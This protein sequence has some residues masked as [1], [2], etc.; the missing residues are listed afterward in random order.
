M[1]F[2]KTIVSATI[3]TVAA[4]AAT[5]YFF[6]QT[7]PNPLEGVEITRTEQLVPTGLFMN[8]GVATQP[9]LDAKKVDEFYDRFSRY[10]SDY[11][12]ATVVTYDLRNT[13]SHEIE[14]FSVTFG[15]LLSARLADDGGSTSASDDTKTLPIR[16]LPSGKAKLSVLYSGPRTTD[17]RFLIDGQNVPI[18][19]NRVSEYRDPT[20]VWIDEHPGYSFLSVS[21]GTV[22]SVIFVIYVVG[23]AYMRNRPDL[24][25]QGASSN[26]LALG[27]ATL[28]RLRIENPKKFDDVVQRATALHS[29]WN[30]H[31]GVSTQKEET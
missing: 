26:E 5:F 12:N 18:K 22:I 27:L 29:K 6:S 14:K 17:E 28:N 11:A 13:S 1:S 20:S 7:P 3:P 24:W 30:G 23:K 10:F 2:L 31:L 16:L 9:D 15:K 21:G 19:E 8:L 25:V 4:A